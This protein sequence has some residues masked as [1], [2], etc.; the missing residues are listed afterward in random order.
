MWWEVSGFCIVTEDVFLEPIP[1]RIGRET[2]NETRQK[3]KRFETQTDGRWHRTKKCDEKLS[4]FVLYSHV[5]LPAVVPARTTRE[6][7]KK[8]RQ[9]DKCIEIQTDGP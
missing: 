8:T 1:A 9:K 4:V 2:L 7:F 6:R 3:H 5:P